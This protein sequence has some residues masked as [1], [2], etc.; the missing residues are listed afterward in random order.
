LQTTVLLSISFSGFPGA[1]GAV[2]AAAAAGSAGA[3]GPL[4]LSAAVGAIASNAAAKTNLIM[5][6]LRLERPAVPNASLVS[7]NRLGD[8][9]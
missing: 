2:I 7:A 6:L 3:A 9:P 4:S 1:A 8:H 5:A